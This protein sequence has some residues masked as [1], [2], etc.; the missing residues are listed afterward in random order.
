M[1]ILVIRFMDITG[2]LVLLLFVAFWIIVYALKSRLEKY[3][4]TIYPFF[5]L[6]RKKS[7]EYWFPKFSRSR[8]YRIYEK[9]SVILGLLLMIASI[10]TIVYI[11]V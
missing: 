2:Y 1:L 6:W 8:G 3:G 5:I 9:I 11:V 7:R 10:A 4:L